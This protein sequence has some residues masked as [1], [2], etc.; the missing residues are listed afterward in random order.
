MKIP[1]GGQIDTT[2]EKTKEGYV[3]V[4][5]SIWDT[6]HW[7]GSGKTIDECL[8]RLKPAKVIKKKTI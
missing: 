7:I 5:W 8:K 2:I 6:N 3:M 1:I 4:V